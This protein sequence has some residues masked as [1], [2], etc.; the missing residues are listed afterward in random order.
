MKKN[1]DNNNNVWRTRDE[2]KIISKNY[3]QKQLRRIE[4]WKENNPYTLLSYGVSYIL[5]L[6]IM[7]EFERK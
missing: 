5:H 6:T 3:M 2:E 1:I 4:K 7:M